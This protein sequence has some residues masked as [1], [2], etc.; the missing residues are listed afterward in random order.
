VK[1]LGADRKTAG[2]VFP[3]YAI[4]AAKFRGVLRG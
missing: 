1:H 3:G 2:A 4:D